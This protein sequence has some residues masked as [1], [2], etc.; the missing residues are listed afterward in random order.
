MIFEPPLQSAY[1]IKRYKRF[2]ADVKNES[3]EALTLHCPNTGSMKA[4]L[5]P[6]ERVWYSDSGNPKRKYPCTWELAETPAGH[7]IVV[8]TGLPNKLIFE[9][10]SEGVI[11][12]LAGYADSRREVRYGQ[13]NS[14]IDI[15]LTDSNKPDCF[16]E[17]KNVTLLEE[18]GKGY[19]PDAVS[20][21]GQ[22][23]LRELE[24][25]VSL[26]NRGVLVFCVSHT[27]I[28]S[29][30]PAEHIDPAYANILREVAKK[31]VE[32]L[33]YR[34]DV[35]PQSVDVVRPIPVIL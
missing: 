6:E 12:E 3:E 8:N 25:E 20:T 30:S 21:R 35:S 24:R 29:V 19:F 33:A 18:D 13:E 7:F 31:G 16:V 23:H 15:L 22:K 9:A 27:G 34:C 32:I 10:I 28:E 17:V 5:Y 14:R 2:M 1:L 11:S 26:G 4:C